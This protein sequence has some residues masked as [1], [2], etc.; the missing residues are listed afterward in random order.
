M[1]KPT[2]DLHDILDAMAKLAAHPR[3]DPQQ[4]PLT[5]EQL[6]AAELACARMEAVLRLID[7]DLAKVGMQCAV[8]FRVHKKRH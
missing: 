8:D 5:P 2:P 6:E 3:Y 7:T 4:E 1:P